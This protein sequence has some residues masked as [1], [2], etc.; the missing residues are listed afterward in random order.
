MNNLAK[1]RTR[2][3]RK[4][5]WKTAAAQVPAALAHVAE[6][7]GWE[8]VLLAA[9]IGAWQQNS[10]AADRWDEQYSQHQRERYEAWARLWMRLDEVFSSLPEGVKSVLP[11]WEDRPEESKY[12]KRQDEHDQDS[13]SPMK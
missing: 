7:F 11:K 4:L 2:Y 8:A 3:F 9:L 13:G 1:R 6:E 5:R 12:V 10:V